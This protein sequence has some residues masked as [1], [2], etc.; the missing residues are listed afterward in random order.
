M[1]GLITDI[2]GCV[3]AGGAST[4]FGRD[5]SLFA[6]RGKPL[7]EHVLGVLS[8]IFETNIIIADECAKF[9]HLG[10]PC[11][12][13]LI[14]GMGPLGGLYTGLSAVKTPRLF[15]VACDMPGLDAGLIRHLASVSGAADVTVPFV[16]GNYEA[17]HAVYSKNCEPAVKKTLDAGRRRIVSFFD[18][19]DVRKVEEEEILRYAEPGMVFGNINTMEDLGV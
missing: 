11:H 8:G 9:A 7:I 2:T 16:D 15:A 6:Y 14:P 3:I 5:K 17:L 1:S 4:R 12:A 18:E 13:D 19:V 10:L